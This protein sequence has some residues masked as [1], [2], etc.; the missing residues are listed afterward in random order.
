MAAGRKPKPTNLKLIQGTYRQDRAR[1]FEPK[2]RI[3]IPPCPKFL[4]GEA[5]KQFKETAKK[6]ARIGL[7]TELDDMALSMLCQGWQ[8]YL[9]ATEQV[10]KSGILVKS[11]NGFPVLNPYLTVA[12]QALKKVRSLLAEFGMTPGSRSRINAAVADDESD[13]EWAKLLK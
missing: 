9:E 1:P 5:Q 7:M 12:N 11:P 13:N 3:T 8:E 2:P 4:Q 10:R 6:L